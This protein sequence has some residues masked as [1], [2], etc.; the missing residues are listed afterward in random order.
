MIDLV[1]LTHPDPVAAQALVSRLVSLH[2]VA[3]GHLLPAGTS[4]FFW[5]NEVK[6]VRETTVLLKSIRGNRQILEQEIRRDHPYTVPEILFLAVDHGD[7]GYLS[8]V[9]ES[10]SVFP[11]GL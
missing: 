10:C 7:A 3:C 11:E 6:T 1:L 8:W 9:L 4:V 5:E 2:L